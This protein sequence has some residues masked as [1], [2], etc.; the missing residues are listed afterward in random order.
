MT[1]KFLLLLIF[2]ISSFLYPEIGYAQ[3]LIVW[4]KDGHGTLYNLNNNVKATFHGDSLA[5]EST[6]MNVTYPLTDIVRFT[7]VD[8]PTSVDVVGVNDVEVSY[9]NGLLLITGLDKGMDVYVYSVDGKLLRKF[10][11]QSQPLSISLNNYP[12]GIY[13]VKVGSATYKIRIQ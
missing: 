10:V 5:I 8:L 7:Y 13:I 1:R 11:S 2:I 4:K 12:R 3:K 9:N 6:F